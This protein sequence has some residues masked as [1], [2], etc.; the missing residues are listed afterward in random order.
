MLSTTITLAAP[1]VLKDAVDDLTAGVTR[2]KLVFYGGLIVAIAAASGLVRFATRRLVI[3]VSRAI[4]YDLRNA[5]FAHLQTLPVSFFQSHRTGDLM[6]RATNDLS[7]VRMMVGPAV[8]YASSTGLTFVV[9]LGFMFSLNARL[10]WLAL[11]PLPLVTLTTHYFGRAIHERFERIQSQFSDLSAVTQEALAGVRV[12]RAYRQE[13]REMERFRTANL[14]YLDRN[15]RLIR[16]Q[17][18]FYPSMSVFMGVAQLIVLWIG[19]RDVIA[20]RMTVG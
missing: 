6:S 16:L 2:S 18:M 15:R 11:I 3:G 4:E 14:E 1:W 5:F 8:L 9:A 13:S 7:A 12:V 10:T 17:G 19:A 20:S